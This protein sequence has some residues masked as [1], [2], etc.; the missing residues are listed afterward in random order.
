MSRAEA[1]RGL[2]F[3]LMARRPHEKKFTNVDIIL[4]LKQLEMTSFF[5]FLS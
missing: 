1:N 2:L 4:K 5:T 3:N